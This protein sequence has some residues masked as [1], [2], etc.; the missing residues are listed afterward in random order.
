[1]ESCAVCPDFSDSLG[2]P[3][4]HGFRAE[5][6]EYGMQPVARETETLMEVYTC[7]CMYVQPILVNED[8]SLLYLFLLVFDASLFISTALPIHFAEINFSRLAV[9]NKTWLTE[10]L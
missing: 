7:V 10:F 3:R 5:P 6:S 2:R 8:T 4:Q 9:N 1:M